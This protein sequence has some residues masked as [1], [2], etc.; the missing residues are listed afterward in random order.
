MLERPGAYDLLEGGKGRRRVG[1]V[2]VDGATIKMRPMVALGT[3]ASPGDGA[4]DKPARRG[5][6]RRWPLIV[7]TT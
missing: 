7:C 5:F 3:G 6:A 1:F 4:T 2:A